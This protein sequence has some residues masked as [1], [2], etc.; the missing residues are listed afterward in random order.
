MRFPK[1]PAHSDFKSVIDLINS[2]NKAKNMKKQYWDDKIMYSFIM[3]KS[4][5]IQ[6]NILDFF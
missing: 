5:A 4:Q 2:S 6:I 1:C 3:A